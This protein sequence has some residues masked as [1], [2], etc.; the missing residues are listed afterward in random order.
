[1]GLKSKYTTRHLKCLFTFHINFK[2]I[3][4]LL[5]RMYKKKKKISIFLFNWG[6][7]ML[8]AKTEKQKIHLFFKV[9]NPNVLANIFIFRFICRNS[10]SKKIFNSGFNLN[11]FTLKILSIKGIFLYLA[12]VF[13]PQWLHWYSCQCF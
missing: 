9:L 10:K 2:N 12:H 6:Y 4:H 13:T 3:Y 11:I 8:N 7:F 1:M 5:H